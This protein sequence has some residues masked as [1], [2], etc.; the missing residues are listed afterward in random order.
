M[1][2]MDTGPSEAGWHPIESALRCTQLYYI[3]QVLKLGRDPLPEP[4]IRGSICHVGLAHFYERQRRMQSGEPFD[5]LYSPLDAMEVLWRLMGANDKDL[6]TRCQRAIEAYFQAYATDR[7]TRIVAVEKQYEIQ[8]ASGRYTARVDLHV[9]DRAGMQWFWDHKSSSRLMDKTGA[10]YTHSGQILGLQ[11][12]GSRLYG[13]S[14]GGVRLNLLSVEDRPRFARCAPGYNLGFRRKFE[15]MVKTGRDRMR[16][17]N[18]LSWDQ[19]PP[20]ATELSCETIYGPCSC[21]EIC[22]GGIFT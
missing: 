11:E 18:Q 3:T 4:L 13:S 6:L 21:L 14:F 17:L 10:R 12:I 2:L 7:F 20:V 8:L 1:E 19:V 5:R 9:E 16:I 15:I 22:K